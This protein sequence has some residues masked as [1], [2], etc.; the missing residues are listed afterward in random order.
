M[1]CHKHCFLFIHSLLFKK[2][3]RTLQNPYICE[4]CKKEFNKKIEKEEY[5]YVDNAD[6]E[7]FANMW[8][9]PRNSP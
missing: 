8:N 5:S 7:E 3:L 4:K 1:M 6:K 9:L 2:T